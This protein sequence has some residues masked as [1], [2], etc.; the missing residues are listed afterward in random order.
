M[1]KKPSANTKADGSASQQHRRDR[2]DDGERR[3]RPPGRLMI[4]REIKDDAGAEG[5]GKP[6]Q[7]AAGAD[8]D[9]GPFADARGN[10]E[11]GVGPEAV[12]PAARSADRPSSYA[13]PR[14]SPHA[15]L[16]V[17]LVHHRAPQKRKKPFARPFSV[18]GYTT[19]AGLGEPRTGV[20]PGGF[21]KASTPS[22]S[23]SRP[24]TLPSPTRR[25][26]L[27]S[28]RRKLSPRCRASRRCG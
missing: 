3:R 22:R 2:G 16:R 18:G 7:Q 12:P 4:G 5:D 26:D 14:A 9:R 19:R 11:L 6:R 24:A 27:L 8:L 28:R 17:A 21:A 13:G 1:A 20:G 25:R 10:G 23:A 15:I